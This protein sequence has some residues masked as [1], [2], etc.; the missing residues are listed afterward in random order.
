MSHPFVFGAKVHELDAPAISMSVVEFTYYADNYC[1]VGCTYWLEGKVE[2]VHIPAR[3]LVE[4][5]T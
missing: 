4:I 5:P 1:E 3:R 2:V